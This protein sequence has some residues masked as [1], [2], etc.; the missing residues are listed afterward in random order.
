M[1]C[2]N[3]FLTHKSEC[4]W[5]SQMANIVG[6]ESDAQYIC[7]K[8]DARI[9]DLDAN[10]TANWLR[11]QIQLGP[12]T[13]L[14]GA[15]N[16]SGN[17]KWSNEVQINSTSTMAYL[18]ANYVP[19]GQCIHAS[20]CNTSKP[21]RWHVADCSTLVPFLCQSSKC[22]S[23]GHLDYV[24]LSDIHPKSW[25]ASG[26]VTLKCLQGY[27]TPTSTTEQYLKC[28]GGGKWNVTAESCILHTCNSPTQVKNSI[29]TVIKGSHSLGDEVEYVCKPGY[30]SLADRS[31]KQSCQ[32]NGWV[33]YNNEQHQCDRKY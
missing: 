21:L 13:T 12:T 20:L 9:S 22:S 10:D 19:Q 23:L 27:K 31:Y 16:V 15:K 5:P 18:T 33:W 11:D 17:F 29:R 24:D 6:T 4:Y 7:S 26:S 14:I 8:L 28:E 2:P 32:L 1:W 3:D 25:Y 30:D